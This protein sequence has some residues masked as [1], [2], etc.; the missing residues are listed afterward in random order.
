MNN[1]V[2]LQINN[3]RKVFTDGLSTPLEVL[4]GINL[5]I[6]QGEFIS[7][8]GESGSGKSTLLYQIGFL[9]SPTEGTVLINGKDVNKLSDKEQSKIRRESIGFVFQFY[10]LIPNLSVE[11]NILLPVI[12]AGKKRKDY[13]EK[14]NNLLR[15]VG[16]SEKRKLLP[17]QLSGGQQQ[18]VAIA[19]AVIMD[20]C[21]ILADEP[22]G[23]LDS[24]STNE[25]MRLFKKLNK[26]QNI[27][28]I[29]VTHSN[30]VA[31]FGDKIIYLKDGQIV[32]NEVGEQT[33]EEI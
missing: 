7:L 25:I 14:L 33:N 1:E 26:E 27:T 18:R 4:K 22:T 31:E 23:N 28:I 32:T 21:L 16:L 9:D 3:L 13:E 11:D 5:T 19:R 2:I 10:N 24:I 20:P 12:L 17:K 29:Q 15:T 6:N 30:S 8:M